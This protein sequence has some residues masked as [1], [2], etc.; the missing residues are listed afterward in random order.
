MSFPPFCSSSLSNLLCSSFVFVIRLLVPLSS[1]LRHHSSLHHF[2]SSCFWLSHSLCL[3]VHL[4]LMCHY[5][6][7][8]PPLSVHIPVPFL[9]PEFSVSISLS[10]P[11]ALFLLFWLLLWKCLF[12]SSVVSPACF[13]FSLPCLI[14]VYHVEQPNLI[15]DVVSFTDS[16]KER[17]RQK[18]ASVSSSWDLEKDNKW[19]NYRLY[20]RPSTICLLLIPQSSLYTTHCILHRAVCSLTALHTVY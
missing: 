9:P 2:L 18:E 12:G 17:L 1:L 14:T 19:N 7:H 11:L 8:H 13:D 6:D 10:R 16:Q 4:N 3:S 15:A 5:L 20:H